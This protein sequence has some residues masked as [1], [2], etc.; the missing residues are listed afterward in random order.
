MEESWFMGTPSEEPAGD[1]D[2]VDT[3]EYWVHT[4][5]GIPPV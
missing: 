4:E 3:S 2:V 1:V 5:F